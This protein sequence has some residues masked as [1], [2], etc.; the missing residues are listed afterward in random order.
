MIVS[1]LTVFAFLI[2]PFAASAQTVDIGFAGK[3]VYFSKDTLYV[4]DTVRIYARLRNYGD[5]D[6]TGVVG[7]YVSSEQIGN[8]QVI[9]LPYDGF[10]EEVFIDFVVPPNE[11]NIYARVDGTD[12]VDQ[13]T[14]NNIVN[15]TLMYPVYDEDQDGVLDDDDNCPSDANADQ[16]DTDGDGVGDACDIDDDND[17]LTDDVEE[18]LGTDPTDTD[19]DDDGIEDA[20]DENPIVFDEPVVEDEPVVD[21]PHV[22]TP[23]V[24]EPQG[25]IARLFTFGDDEEVD[26]NGETVEVDLGEPEAISARAIFTVHQIGWNKFVFETS[27]SD[28]VPVILSWSFGDG[29]TSDEARVEHVYP[30]A[31]TYEVLLQ[32]TSQDGTVDEDSATVV[33]TFFHL[34]NPVFLAFVVV[35]VIILLL[36][37]ATMLRTPNTKHGR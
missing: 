12:P 21:P 30:G 28:V 18:S 10:D 6:T 7:F 37:L 32:V 2:L 36:A 31:G 14:S 35:L 23:P 3:G 8:S 20:D 13:N 33:I 16:L 29:E 4:G 5:V 34:A 15:T 27:Q 17:T 11:F 1:S 19:T 24:N 9:S 25:V 26:E 22:N